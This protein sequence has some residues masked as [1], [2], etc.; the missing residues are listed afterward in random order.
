MRE[1]KKWES[2]GR[3]WER[4]GRGVGVKWERKWEKW[5]K[6]RGER[7]RRERRVGRGKVMGEGNGSERES[8]T[9]AKREGEE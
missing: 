7:G 9:E 3:E 8:G 2:S 5:E 6:E 4:I 1:G